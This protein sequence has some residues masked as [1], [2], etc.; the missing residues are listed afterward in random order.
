MHRCTF[1][2]NDKPMSAFTIGAA[3]FPAF[4]GRDSHINKRVSACFVNLGPI[5]PGEYY[6]FDRQGGGRLEMFR[7]L[8]NNNS[9]WFALY[10]ID[11][12]IDDETYCNR[13]KRGNFRLHPKGP[14]GI[15]EGCITIE[16]LTDFHFIRAILK[17]TTPSAV[18]GSDLKAYGKVTVR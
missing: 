9:E 11:G 13:V 3:S 12:K 6:I 16:K 10:A 18:P 1:E 17:S 7:N 5:P 2:L 8:F 4:S 14:R 15:S